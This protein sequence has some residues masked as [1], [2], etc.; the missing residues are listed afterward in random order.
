MKLRFFLIFIFMIN[1]AFAEQTKYPSTSK[2]AIALIQ[3]ENIFKVCKDIF[4]NE[5]LEWE[6]R[7]K[8]QI[9][10][11]GSL[12][13]AF[14][15]SVEQKIGN[16]LKNYTP[17]AAF[18]GE[19]GYRF[20]PKKNYGK[21]TWYIDPVDGTI[22]F[23]NGLDTFGLTL[24]LVKKR[25]PIATLIYFPKLSAVYTAYL[26][27]GAYKNGNSLKLG[28]TLITKHN[29]IAHSDDYAFQLTNRE[30]ILKSLKRLPY[31]SRSYTDIYA[32][33]LV[34]EGKCIAKVDAAGALWDLFP[35]LLLIRE[36]GGYA[37]FYPI[38]ES[39]DDLYGSMIVGQKAVVEQIHIQLMNDGC[40]CD[41]VWHDNQIPE[42]K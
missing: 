12:V 29:I 17:W 8:F 6:G 2:D 19:E 4:D 25:E 37:R 1:T 18:L 28:T 24:T 11:D 10:N 16:F 20:V 27:E 7:N 31:V 39:T 15:K 41:T 14:E 38:K 5:Y 13:S 42:K 36:A 9:K 3:K 30:S 23:K 32:Y 22:S 35:G 34:A 26:N 33:T 21:F 40:L